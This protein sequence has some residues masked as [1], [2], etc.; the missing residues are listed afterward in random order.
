MLSKTKLEDHAKELN[1]SPLSNQ[2]L[3]VNFIIWL[4]FYKREVA[5]KNGTFLTILF[6][7]KA[8]D[9]N[10]ALVNPNFLCHRI[11]GIP[12]QSSGK[13]RS[14]KFILWTIRERPFNRELYAGRAGPGLTF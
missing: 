7:S 5:S 4:K 3:V 10:S 12:V 11:M 14:C 6:V 8:Y 13:S 9:I 2:N 1:I